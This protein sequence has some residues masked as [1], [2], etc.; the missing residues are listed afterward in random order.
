MSRQKPLQ[1]QRFFVVVIEKF[2][3]YNTIKKV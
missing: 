3:I 1:S 2:L